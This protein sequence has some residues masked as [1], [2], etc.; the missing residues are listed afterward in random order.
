MTRTPNIHDWSA[1]FNGNSC[2]ICPN[3]IPTGAGKAEHVKKH[4]RQGRVE[5]T[6]KGTKQEPFRYVPK[7][8]A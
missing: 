4:V 7:G 6:G 1:V 8:S 5:L 3:W 2:R